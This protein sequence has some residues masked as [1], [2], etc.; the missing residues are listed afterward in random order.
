[1]ALHTVR[2]ILLVFIWLVYF[3]VISWVVKCAYK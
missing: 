3:M 2:H 1:M